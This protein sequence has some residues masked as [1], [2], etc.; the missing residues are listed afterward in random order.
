MPTNQQRNRAGVMV[1]LTDQECQELR[2]LVRELNKGSIGELLD[3]LLEEKEWKE[4]QG[5]R[6]RRHIE[7]S[8]GLW[9][10]FLLPLPRGKRAPWVR[11]LLMGWL[12][13]QQIPDRL[14]DEQ[15]YWEE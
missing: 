1:M 14:R 13:E 12:E 11:E 5:T 9:E 7:V 2:R 6:R 3:R 4:R 10:R 8:R 15:I